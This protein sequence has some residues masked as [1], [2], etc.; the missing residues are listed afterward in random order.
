[1]LA[2]CVVVKILDR[3]PATKG[4]EPILD[5]IVNNANLLDKLKIMHAFK[6][7]VKIFSELLVW[8]VCQFPTYHKILT[9]KLKYEASHKRLIMLCYS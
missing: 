7:H 9:T 5:A 1:M 2:F 8:K 4:H 6:Q 3:L